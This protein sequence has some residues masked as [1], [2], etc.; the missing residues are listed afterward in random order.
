FVS[1]ALAILSFLG[2]SVRWGDGRF[3]VRSD[4][5]L[6]PEAGAGGT[7]SAHRPCRFDAARIQTGGIHVMDADRAIFAQ[8]GSKS[9]LK[10]LLLNAAGFR[11]FEG[12]AAA[13][14]QNRREV[15]SNWYPIWLA[16]PAGMIEGARLLDAQAQHLS[17]AQTLAIAKNYDHVVVYTSS[18]TL[19]GDAR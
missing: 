9:V 12:G 13:R 2:D 3:R 19:L 18:P 10:T 11:E 14:Y 4:G 15:W 17:L 7:G 8:Q 5:R 16:C 1:C 6:E